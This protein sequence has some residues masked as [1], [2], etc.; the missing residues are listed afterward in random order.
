MWDP[1]SGSQ[2]SA[3]PPEASTRAISAT[4]TSGLR[5]VDQHRPAVG[6]SERSVAEGKLLGFA[7]QDLRRGDRRCGFRG[8]GGHR[9]GPIDPDG[10]PR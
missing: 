8:S 2:N 5:G 7:D 1:W 3:R 6:G 9:S 4:A 10:Q